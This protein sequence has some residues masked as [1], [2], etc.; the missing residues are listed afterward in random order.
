MAAELGHLRSFISVASDSHFPIQNLP[1]GIFRRKNNANDAGRVGVAIGDQ[2]L[3]LAAISDAGLFPQQVARAGGVFHQNTLNSFMALGRPSWIETRHVITKLL[4]EDNPT[5]RDNKDLRSKALVPQ[6]EAEMLIPAHIGD[7]TDFYASREHATNVGTMWR[8]KENALM[9]NWLHIPIGYHGRASSVVV[10]GTP[11][12]RPKGQTRP[13]E[14]EP[15]LYGPS[16]VVD[17]ELEMAWFIG[18]GNNLGDPISVEKADD[19]IFGM[20]LMNDWS[21]RDIQKWEYQPLG[22]F[23]AKNWA[24]TVSPWIVTLE[25]LEP[26][27]VSGPPQEPTPLPYLQDKGPSTFDINLFTYIQTE[28]STSPQQLCATNFK[29]LY[30]SMKQ[31]TSHHTVSGCNMRP[32]DLLASGTISGSTPDSLG[33]LLELTWGGQKPFTIAETGEERKY[34]QDGDSVIFTGFCQGNGY[35][36]GFGQCVGKILPAHP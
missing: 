14:D 24:T 8:G 36:I 12:R 15:P 25:A 30:W 21:A 1:Y 22:P 9:P 32:G 23:T 17:Y 6:S 11:I 16:R 13:K 31:Q 28:K 7:Y 4:S 18:P 29:Y 35:R 27:R 5:L 20:V 33:S 34:L 26:F 2:I 3:D 10:S 19:H